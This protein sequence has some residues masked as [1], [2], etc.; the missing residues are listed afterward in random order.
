MKRI[1]VYLYAITAITLCCSGLSIA[2]SAT[3]LNTIVSVVAL[4]ASV[5]SLAI[6]HYLVE[7]VSNDQ[8]TTNRNIIDLENK[9]KSLQEKNKR[10][11]EL[12]Q[13]L[14]KALEE[15]TEQATIL[16]QEIAKLKAELQRIDEEGY[17]SVALN[18]VKNFRNHI[19]TQYYEQL[20]A[21][22]EPLTQEA[23]QAIID[24]TIDMAMLAFDMAET[25]DW[26]LS[27][28]EEQKLNI[29]IINDPESRQQSVEEAIIITDNPTITPKWAR[30]LGETFKDIVSKEANIIY[31]GYKIK[32]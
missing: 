13:G 15:E 6:I 4:V 23:R 18:T 8:E 10:D 17:F 1:V 21:T 20:R 32:L 19:T 11:N 22:D 5:L 25:I 24:S 28:R 16:K 26:N 27:N 29:E 30:L 31:S 14:S 3:K 7:S 2:C 12:K 9:L